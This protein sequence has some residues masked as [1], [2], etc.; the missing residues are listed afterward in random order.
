[1]SGELDIHIVMSMQNTSLIPKKIT[2]LIDNIDEYLEEM[3]I[4]SDIKAIPNELNE[5]M[6]MYFRDINPDKEKIKLLAVFLIDHIY[7]YAADLDKL[8]NYTQI[9]F[10]TVITKLWDTIQ[11]RGIDTFYILDNEIRDD[12][13]HLTVQLFALSGIAVVFPYFVKGQYLTPLSVTEQAKWAMSFTQDDFDS[14]K[15]VI[16]VDP[17]SEARWNELSSLILEYMSHTRNI[18]YIEKDAS[19]NFLDRVIKIAK[20]SKYI[21]VFRNKAPQDPN[22]TLLS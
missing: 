21:V 7:R 18:V 6:W 15:V 4:N 12:R 2:D 14:N 17:H 13:F 8:D 22:V 1:M 11:S 10:G 3:R 9:Y 19:I 20:E 16:T 5:Y